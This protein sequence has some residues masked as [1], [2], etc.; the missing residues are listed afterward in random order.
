MAAER[1][2][3][4]TRDLVAATIVLHDLDGD[5][6]CEAGDLAPHEDCTHSDGETCTTAD[7]AAWEAHRA[8]MVLAALASKGLLVAPDDEPPASILAHDDRCDRPLGGLC[9]C[10]EWER[11]DLDRAAPDDDLCDCSEGLCAGFDGCRDEVSDAD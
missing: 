2:A 9:N 5:F 7:I 6:G 10:A 3:A 1:W 11:F 4:E 8:D